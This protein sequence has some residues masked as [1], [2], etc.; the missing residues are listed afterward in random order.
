MKYSVEVGKI[1]EGALS[2]NNQ[3]MLNYTE[4]L[5]KNLEKDNDHRSAK[6]FANL[7][8]KTKQ[9]TLNPMN[10]SSVP[11]DKESRQNLVD[12]FYP[13]P[14]QHNVILNKINEEQV[15]LFIES[16]EK[17]D[18]LREKGVESPNNLLIY[19]PPGT[20]KTQT[21]FYIARELGLPL[22]VSRLDSLISS[23]LGTTAK[24]IQTIFQYA[25]NSP[26]VLFLDEFDAIAKARD[27]ENELGELKRVVNSLIQNIDFMSNDSILIVATNHEKLLDNAIWRRF[28][29]KIEI[30]LPNKKSIKS[31][32]KEYN[33]N[34]IEFTEDDLEELSNLFEGITGADIKE[35][36]FRA[37]KKNIL[38]EKDQNVESIYT[39]YFNFIRSSYEFANERDSNQV[40]AKHLREKNH[41][42]FT[43]KKIGEILNISTST[44]SNL[45][46]ED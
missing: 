6:K 36:F 45:L 20:G 14:N 44:V 13:N 3:K 24:N 27:D 5:I 2:H 46:K 4:L 9:T 43:Y 10:T 21:A 1:I 18:L 41:K 12:I 7:L 29:Y 31:L 22:Y 17:K 42:I 39:E 34:H 32:L 8:E 26:S 37:I 40:K 11:V 23:Y 25:E 38:D 16:Y 30:N 33:K 28:N 19:G 15:K 35:I